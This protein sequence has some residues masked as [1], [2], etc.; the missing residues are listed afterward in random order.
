MKETSD[1]QLRSV[2]QDSVRTWLTSWDF[3]DNPFALWEASQEAWLDRYYIKRPFFNHLLN[4]PRS[5][6]IYAK[7]G[8]GKSATRIMLESECRPHISN[9]PVLAIPFTGF[10]SLIKKFTLDGKLDIDDYLPVLTSEI[11]TKLLESIIKNP[12]LIA[13]VSSHHAH[14]ISFWLE[15]YSIHTFSNYSLK[16]LLLSADKDLQD[17]T[18]REIIHGIQRKE[19]LAFKNKQMGGVY[20][21]L[22]KIQPTNL[23]PPKLRLDTPIHVIEELKS[24]TFE[25]LNLPSITCKSI[26]ILIDGIDEYPETQNSPQIS[27]SILAPLLGNM[28]YLELTDFATKFFLPFE[29]KNFFEEKYRPD[30]INSIDL[31]WDDSQK[32]SLRTLFRRRIST[33]NTRGLI[34]LAELCHPSIRRW[35]EDAMLD[36]A[37]K[38]P[39]NLLRLGDLLFLEHCKEGPNPESVILPRE[40]EKAVIAFRGGTEVDENV[41]YNVVGE[42]HQKESRSENNEPNQI[43][44]DIPKLRVDIKTGKVYRGSQVLDNLPNLQFRLIKYLYLN[45][46][47]ICEKEE[48]AIAVY[49]LDQNSEY[50]K[51]DI[52]LDIAKLISRLKSS[53]ELDRT[54]PVYI[55]TVRGRGY[56]LENTK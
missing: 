4:D 38:S 3:V 18:I 45:R 30:R 13:K 35:I 22:T 17:T 20:E 50:E 19:K 6:V 39:R 43:S 55:N 23:T 48:I 29:Q 16:K 42:N 40:W 9:S 54:K 44:D 33:F 32:D 2:L 47:R 27:A 11:L 24:F 49:E 28:E 10:S 34:S 37:N 36:E 21:F 53:I 12:H 52:E 46:G 14:E 1:S 26:Y 5:I 25:I 7:R 8:G 51:K 56:R 41:L 31:T 15:K